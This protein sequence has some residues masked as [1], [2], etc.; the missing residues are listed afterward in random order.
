MNGTAKY[1]TVNAVQLEVKSPESQLGFIQNPAKGATNLLFSNTKR[2]NWEV[3]VYAV[4]G[5]LLKRYDFS[6]AL[7]GK[8]NTAQ[9]FEQRYLHGEINKQTTQEQF[10][11]QLI[12]Q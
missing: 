5:Q 9:E 12:I 1:S 3:S 7:T 10:V 6:N 11:Q 2:G 4:S 8:I